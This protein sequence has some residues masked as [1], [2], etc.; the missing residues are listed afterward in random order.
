MASLDLIIRIVA[1]TSGAVNN[2]G[3]ATT[4]LEK[5]EARMKGLAG[6]SYAAIGGVVALG[7]AAAD[8]ASRQQQAIGSL[9][10]VFGDNAA[11]V[12][13]WS[14][15]AAL[16]VGLSKAEYAELASVMG[17]QMKNMGM[18]LDTAAVSTNSLVA[19]GA[20][21][22]A[23][24]GGSSKEAVEAL[25]SA[26]RGEA[27]PAERY[28]LSLKQSTIQAHLAAKGQGDLTG[29]ALEAAKAQ[30]IVELATSQAGG[31][32]GQFAREADTAAGA[33]QRA[34]A[35]WEDASATLGTA[36]LP[37][38]QQLAALVSQL[39]GW[40][41]EN[42]AT[43]RIV[44]AALLGLAATV[45]GVNAA[46]KVYH[47]AQALW[48]AGTWLATKAQSALSAAMSASPMAK[49]IA[50][51]GLLV[52]AIVY[53]WNNCETFRNIVIAVWEAIQ[54]AFQASIDFIMGVVTSVADFLVGVWDGIMSGVSSAWDWIG[55][56]ITGIWDAV[57]GA[58][59]AVWNGIKSFI[60]GI[61]DWH[62]AAAQK[63]WEL[64]RKFIIDPLLAA[65]NW[66]TG[67]FGTIGSWFSSLWSGIVSTAGSVWGTIYS[68]I[69]QPLLN[70]WNWITGV[71]GTI[72]SWFSSLWQGIIDSMSTIFGGAA[73]IV[74]DA[75][76]GVANF[77]KGVINGIIRFINNTV[78]WGINGLIDGANLVPFVDIPH[79]SQI[80]LIGSAAGLPGG[81]WH[82]GMPMNVAGQS[83]VFNISGAVDPDSTA[84]QIK[85]LLTGRDQRTRPLVIGGRP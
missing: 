26:L 33:Q 74:S 79:L 18:D 39:S 9:E 44:G 84:R 16:S 5:F 54:A 59:S 42:E 67:V 31:V 24:F 4:G 28:G 3:N 38:M 58:T 36:L 55:S 13:A 10:S 48:T 29:A 1:Q 23:A 63:A 82:G 68:W 22:S 6:P 15:Q 56:F 47:A 61:W 40:L 60:G 8:S 43:V 64:V 7:K 50:V 25:G 20:D 27:D 78:I 53:L 14:D 83:I 32:V 69:V 51:I 11:Q 71:F 21:L 30:A 76:S 73:D 12:K 34:A 62:V 70:A 65:Y 80:P 37:Y 75:F 2:I 17:A 57:S 52:A 81:E 45:L 19:L 41:V 72:G 49:I 85:G 35:Q 66:V 46:I 77:I